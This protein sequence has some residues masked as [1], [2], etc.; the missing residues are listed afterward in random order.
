MIGL[1]T[2]KRY[3]SKGQLKAVA[4]AFI[5]KNTYAN[6]CVYN[7]S[8]SSLAKKINVS[9]YSIKKYVDILISNGDASITTNGTLCI[10]RMNYKVKEI[11]KGKLYHKRDLKLNFKNEYSQKE[12]I[13]KLNLNK[14]EYLIRYWILRVNG[15]QQQYL[16]DSKKQVLDPT[17][18][19][20][21][22]AAKRKLKKLGIDCSDLSEIQFKDGVTFTI[23]TISNLL[24][25]SIT[26]LYAMFKYWTSIG[27]IKITR[28]ITPIGK[29][30]VFDTEGFINGLN[31]I[32]KC[33]FVSK[34]NYGY[35][36][37]SNLYSFYS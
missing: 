25:V 13:I 12:E 8:P 34:N 33:G 30:K 6:S 29:T 23:E 21:F 22:K 20:K 9:Y 2:I 36:V 1:R 16:V 3:E 28:R 4:L 32:G 15:D 10:H 18:K 19:K 37:E 7:Y 26:K 11:I 27:I 35:I 31:A 5:I 24:N 17:S 14:V